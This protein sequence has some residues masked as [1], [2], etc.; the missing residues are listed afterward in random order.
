MG[1]GVNKVI[2]IGHLGKDPE[3]RYAPSGDA[4]ANVSMA[5]TETWR[6][7]QTGEQREATEWHNLVFSGPLGEIAGKYLK[8]GSRLYIEGKLRTRKWT[9]KEGIDRYTTEIRVRELAMLDSKR[10]DHEAPAHSASSANEY[11]QASGRNSRFAAAPSSTHHSQ[12]EDNDIP[13]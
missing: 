5:T 6:D 2:L 13:F 8:K 11:A 7:K 9:D 12:F 10:A 4:F 1:R 3:V